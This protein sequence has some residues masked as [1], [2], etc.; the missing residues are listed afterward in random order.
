VSTETEVKIKIAD[1]IDF[2]RQLEALG[3]VRFSARHFE[4]N[5]LLD[6]PNESLHKQHRLVRIR[7]VEGRGVLT[8]KGPPRPDGLFKTREELETG[9]ENAGL[10]L[11]IFQQ[12]GMQVYFRYQKYRQEFEL[13]G[14]LIAI[15]ETPIGNYVELEG[16]KESIRSLAQKLGFKESQFVSLSYYALYEENCRNMGMIPRFMV[17][18][19]LE[20]S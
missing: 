15:D 1:P 9:L 14:V 13:D 18:K 7:L 2:C 3:S 4:D 17:F 20:L 6:F 19:D 8:Y 12:I 5:H 16:A 10:A 11:Q